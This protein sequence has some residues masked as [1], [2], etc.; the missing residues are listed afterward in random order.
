MEKCFSSFLP[1]FPNS[2]VPSSSFSLQPFINISHFA[3]CSQYPEFWDS[4]SVGSARPSLC[5]KTALPSEQNPE[6]SLCGSERGLKVSTWD[7]VRQKTNRCTLALGDGCPAEAKGPRPARPPACLPATLRSQ[8]RSAQNVQ[9]KTSS[10]VFPKC[11]RGF[12]FS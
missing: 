7:P 9:S 11:S 3:R 4:H 2:V 8:N 12:R 6:L 1:Q 5:P 10:F